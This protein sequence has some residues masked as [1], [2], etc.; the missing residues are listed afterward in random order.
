MAR[1]ART[2]RD[3]SE[4]KSLQAAMR[5][6]ARE[7]AARVAEHEQRLARERHERELFA[8]T[9]GPVTPLRSPGRAHIE[10]ERPSPHPRQRELDDAAVL[11]EAL[12]DE[13]DV[14]RLLETDEALS[15]RRDGLGPEVVRKLRRGVWVVHGEIDLHGLR[16]DEAREQLAAFIHE[17]VRRGWRC[18]RVVH[19]K[20]HGSPGR[21][22]V[23]KSKVHRWLVQKSEVMAFVQAR[24]SEGGAGALVVL[25]QP[26]AHPSRPS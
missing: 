14:E 19:G 12:S 24:A 18:V 10:R 7:A 21:V 17:A 11:R 1:P 25:L 26:P 9:V 13:M 5:R 2:I 15:Y 23:L 22:P 20:G 6:E 4:L 8:R 16:S 3:L